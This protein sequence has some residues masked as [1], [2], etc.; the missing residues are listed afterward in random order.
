MSSKILSQIK[1]LE[2]LYIQG[3]ANDTIEK[4]LDKIIS[5][6][7]AIFQQKNAELEANLP[8]FEQQYQ[9]SSA[10]FYQRFHGG[11]LGDEIDF[12]EWNA[13]Y[14]MWL[15]LQKQITAFFG[16]VNHKYS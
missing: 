9:M 2:T 7:L 11:E 14:Q 8:K 3:E 6:K 15:A 10:E 13:F 5:Q 12:V 1:I 16:L 4:T